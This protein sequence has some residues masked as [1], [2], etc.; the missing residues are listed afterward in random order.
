M[1][2]DEH[3]TAQDALPLVDKY[4]NRSPT[5]NNVYGRVSQELR[6]SVGALRTAAWREGK[7]RP[8]RSLKF[9]FSEKEEKLL[10]MICVIHARQGIPLSYSD[11]IDLASIFA[12]KDKKHRFSRKFVQGFISRHHTVL[13][14]GRGKITSPLRYPDATPEKTLSSFP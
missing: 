10:E 14:S 2:A 1:S 3:I 8:R 6:V 13:L 7:K 12:K 5:R 11:F 4:A 9:A